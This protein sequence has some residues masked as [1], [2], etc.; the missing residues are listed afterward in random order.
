MS[1][2]SSLTLIGEKMEIAADL[3][4]LFF[5]LK[6]YTSSVFVLIAEQVLLAR[7]LPFQ[8][9]KLV[10]FAGGTILSH[11]HL[12]CKKSNKQKDAAYYRSCLPTFN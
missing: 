9:P 11:K 2:F 6:S 8:Q 4:C 12:Q 5:K 10:V 7:L 3:F 1:S